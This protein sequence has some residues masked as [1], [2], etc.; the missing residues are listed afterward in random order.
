M[1]SKVT[2]EDVFKDLIVSCKIYGH[3]STRSIAR[4]LNTS[5]Y[6]V[7]KHLKELKVYGFIELV[8]ELFGDDEE[9]YPPAWVYRLTDAGRNTHIYKSRF[10]DEFILDIGW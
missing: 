1:Y 6:Q 7:R 10:Y 3:A 4:R 5:V 9:V 8:C 2:E